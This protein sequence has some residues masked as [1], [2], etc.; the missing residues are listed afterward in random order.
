MTFDQSQLKKDDTS[1]K[2]MARI[3]ERD[4][5]ALAELYR[6]HVAL[7][8]RIISGIVNNEADTDD[9][10]QEIFLEIWNCAKNYSDEKGRAL[11]WITTIARCRAID[12]VRKKQSYFQMQERLSMEPVRKSCQY[13]CEE[14]NSGEV[15]GIFKKFI[16]QLPLA[17]REALHLSF[18]CGLSQREIAVRTGIP[19]GTIKTRLELAIQKVRNAV[20]AFS[21]FKGLWPLHSSASLRH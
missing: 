9:L 14:V 20:L 8:R 17:Q 6:L 13:T 4:D 12:K 11:S 7:L 21:D 16:H 10:I 19:L 1:E 18:Y 2:L 15:S 5:N 3:K